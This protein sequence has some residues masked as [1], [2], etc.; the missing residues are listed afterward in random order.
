M[1]LVFLCICCIII[2]N[3][4][5]LIPHHTKLYNYALCFRYN[6]IHLLSSFTTSDHTHLCLAMHHHVY[7]CP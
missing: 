5:L 1:L 6:I 3:Y 4:Y 7:S 2:A